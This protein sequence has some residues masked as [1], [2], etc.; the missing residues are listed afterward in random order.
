M[1]SNNELKQNELCDEN[2]WLKFCK[3]KKNK[4]NRSNNPRSYEILKPEPLTFIPVSILNSSDE[5]DSISPISSPNIELNLLNSPMSVCTTISSPTCVPFSQC[6]TSNKF[7]E[8]QMSPRK[9]TKKSVFK[10]ERIHAY[11]P[12]SHELFDDANQKKITKNDIDKNL[13]E[14]EFAN[15]AFNN[16]YPDSNI[17]FRYESLFSYGNNCFYLRE[18]QSERIF[19]CDYDDFC[20]L[21]MC[22]KSMSNPDDLIKN[23]MYNIPL[24]HKVF[25][26]YIESG[27]DFVDSAILFSS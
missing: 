14:Y 1:N 27:F 12:K 20:F 21:Y 26:L 4:K 9:K 23:E 8:E 25:E 22:A 18:K 6:A 10:Y 7:N 11:S 2:F 15:T 24:C 3:N 19:R 17:K 16:S 5:F 13:S